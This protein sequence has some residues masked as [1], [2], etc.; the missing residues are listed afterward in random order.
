MLHYFMAHFVLHLFRFWIYTCCNFSYGRLFKLQFFCILPCSWF[1]FLCVALFSCCTFSCVASCWTDFIFL[2]CIALLSCYSFYLAA[3]CCT[4]FMLHFLGIQVSNFINNGLHHWCFFCGNCKT[5]KNT[6]FGKHLWTTISKYF[7]SNSHNAKVSQYSYITEDEW[8]Y[9]T[10][11]RSSRP[12]VLCKKICPSEFRKSHR[13]THVPESP[14]T[15]YFR[16]LLL[17]D[18]FLI[19]IQIYLKTIIKKNLAGLSNHIK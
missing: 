1:T 7:I 8:T 16:R 17:S 4:L 6:Y 5:F 18:Y 10:Q 12:E 2:F 11:I 13:E 19:R 9:L 3:S 15:K 14:F